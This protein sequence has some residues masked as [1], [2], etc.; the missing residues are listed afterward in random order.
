MVRQSATG[1]RRGWM[2]AFA[3]MT[4]RARGPPP[5]RVTPAQA[6]VQRGT[7]HR[8]TARVDACFRRH[9]ERGRN[10]PRSTAR[11]DGC[12]HRHD[13]SGSWPPRPGHPGGS[14][15]PG[16]DRTTG[17]RRGWMPAFA[18]MTKG[19]ATGHG[20]G[21]GWMP[22]FAGMTNGAA[23]G[24]G[25]TARVDACVRRHDNSG[26]CPPDQVTPAEAGVQAGTQ[27][28]ECGEGGCLLSQA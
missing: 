15:G 14:R 20:V 3:G 23:I 9:D 11:V 21:R 17:V 22:A 28:P 7:G 27:P 26:S 12:V 18:G 8:G 5:A 19:A 25:S 1:V 16:G 24:H 2:P 10:G 4:T 13:N 6:G